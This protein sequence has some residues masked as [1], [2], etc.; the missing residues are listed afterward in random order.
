[1]N[2]ATILVIEENKELLELICGLLEQKG[3]HVL[4]ATD[5]EKGLKMLSRLPDLTICDVVMS[6]SSGFEV[7]KKIRA[8]I[9]TSNSVFLLP[10]SGKKESKTK[11]NMLWT[12]QSIEPF[13]GDKFIEMV[14]ELFKNKQDT[15]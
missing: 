8:K 13:E 3:Y 14:D 2:S 11:R 4:V 12:N 7:L 5:G 6:E 9:E 10:V 1:M 15:N